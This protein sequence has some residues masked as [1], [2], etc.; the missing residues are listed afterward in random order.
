VG[1]GGLL[2]RKKRIDPGVP[3]HRE[4]PGVLRINFEV[5]FDSIVIFLFQLTREQAR[6]G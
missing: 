4:E 2:V 3:I 5:R 6:E 1:I